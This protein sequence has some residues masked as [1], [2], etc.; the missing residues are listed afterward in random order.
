MGSTAVLIRLMM[1]S[2]LET[3]Q[4]PRYTPFNEVLIRN[5]V[6]ERHGNICSDEP[7]E[8]AAENLRRVN[9]V[10]TEGNR[11]E[12]WLFASFRFRFKQ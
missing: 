6:G 1:P 4:A 7:R 2:S 3:W 9:V 8:R 5:S 12:V 10:Y 11:S